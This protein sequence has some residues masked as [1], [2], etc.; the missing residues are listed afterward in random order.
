MPIQSSNIKWYKSAL[1]SDTT[2][3]QNGGR[4]STVESVSNVK[5]NVFPD[6]PQS[7][8]VAGSTKMRK[9]FIKIET[10]P[11][12]EMVNARVFLDAPSPGDDFVLLQYTGSQTDTQ[13]QISGSLRHYGMGTLKNSVA[14]NAT[15]IVVTLENGA[16]A[17]TTLQPFKPNDILWI[18][19]QSDINSAGN[20]EYLT[21]GPNAGDVSY[22]GSDC[23]IN[24]VAGVTFAW[25]VGA[26]P[27]KVASSFGI[28]SINTSYAGFTVNSS[29]GSYNV[30]NNLELNGYGSVAQ[31]WTLTVTDNA[32]GAFRLDGDTLGANVATGTMGSDFMP[33][34]PAF[35]K[36]YFKLKSTGWS[37]S[38]ANN[39][40][41][42]FS[43]T[44]AAVPYW[45]KR[46]VP[47]GAASIANT[48]SRVAI[49]G[50]SA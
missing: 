44:P 12:I 22:S 6:V 21:V 48:G 43:T 14:Q 39:D 45:E 35:S 29:G 42:T 8:R 9:M 47:A 50:E 49:S 27:I 36:P 37:G 33:N 2:A 46:V 5:G 30:T 31:N 20:S 1:I 3:S 19:N 38:W 13:D 25:T 18:S 7:E 17:G 26:T 16:M 28:T 10:D 41:I 40:T 32:T 34:N 15:Q 23:T 24:L 11:A 4:L